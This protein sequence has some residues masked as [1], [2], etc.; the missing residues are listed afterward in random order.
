MSKKILYIVGAAISQTIIDKVKIE[1]PDHEV[2]PV[3]D[4]KEMKN[5][6]SYMEPTPIPYVKYPDMYLPKLTKYDLKGNNPWPQPH[7][8]SKRNRNY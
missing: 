1:Y 2:V 7:R 5:H 6:T 8:S 4:E 3:T